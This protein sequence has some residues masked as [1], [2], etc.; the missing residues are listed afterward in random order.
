MNIDIKAT[1]SD[2]LNF[3]KESA[4]DQWDVL[5]PQATEYLKSTENRILSVALESTSGQL[6]PEFLIEKAKEELTILESQAISLGIISATMTQ[7]LVNSTLLKVMGV[8][9]KFLTDKINASANAN[10]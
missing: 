3:F 4:G 2:V 7:S 8:V 6:T 1:L 5:E 9:I 10:P